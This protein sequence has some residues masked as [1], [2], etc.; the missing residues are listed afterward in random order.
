MVRSEEAVVYSG[1][2][3]EKVA[4]IDV[5]F[6][7]LPYS[8][9]EELKNGVVD[10]CNDSFISQGETRLKSIN[11][12]LSKINWACWRGTVDVV[13][14]EVPQGFSQRLPV[15]GIFLLNP[16]FWLAIIIWIAGAVIGALIGKWIIYRVVV[17]PLE[18]A[19]QEVVN[20]ID[21]VIAKKHA[22]LAAGNITQE[23]SDELDAMLQDARDDADDAGD[24]PRYD[25]V[26]YL[27]KVLELGKFIPCVV[28]GAVTIAA[29]KVVSAYAPRR[30]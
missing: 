3:P 28:G 23:F 13:G 1:V 24:D 29:L 7:R 8:T 5:D 18:L 10:V 19:L 2:E 4:E 27:E 20:D 17:R 12:R 30:D 6:I 21:D 16:A 25:W 11:P 26:D 9:D 22:D 15:Q 14:S